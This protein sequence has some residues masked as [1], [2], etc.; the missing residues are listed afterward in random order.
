MT[1]IALAAKRYDGANGSAVFTGT[2]PF[3]PGVMQESAIQNIGL[4]DG[5]TQVA[6]RKT[7]LDPSPLHPDGS[8]KVVKID[9]TLSVSAGSTLA[10]TAVTGMSPIG[11]GTGAVTIDLA[12]MDAPRLL[13]CTDP[14]YLCT[15]KLLGLPMV[16]ATS[17][18]LPASWQTFLTTQFT[19]TNPDWPAYGN[20]LPYINMDPAAQPY[21]T[22]PWNEQ[23]ANYEG[24]APFYY[25]YLMT[26]DLDWLRNG[27]RCAA[28]GNHYQ[29]GDRHP[30]PGY[31]GLGRAWGY[32]CQVRQLT[33]GN[34][35]ITYN[36]AYGSHAAGEIYPTDLGAPLTADTS[37]G[38]SCTG[39]FVLGS[40]VVTNVVV[41]SPPPG[42][43]GTRRCAAAARSCGAS[44]CCSGRC[45][46]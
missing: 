31:S 30:N 21:T 26:G 10:L 29:N 22:T 28:Y 9:A 38:L 36:T 43:I 45:T 3:P 7:L 33:W 19:R 18:S 32:E 13:G 24:L 12:W 20:P 34:G 16:P 41:T 1:T 35:A 2:I 27:H 46:P 6:C 15:T 17:A 23:S 25:Y 8:L 37:T 42:S 4:F 44:T 5:S 40:A 39:D 11:G 14:V